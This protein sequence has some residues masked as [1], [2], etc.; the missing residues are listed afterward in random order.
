MHGPTQG[1]F[2]ARTLAHP[3]A[4]EQAGAKKP[5][6]VASAGMHFGALSDEAERRPIDTLKR[7]RVR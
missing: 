3:N 7:R 4:Q 1:E 2:I 6:R 5:M